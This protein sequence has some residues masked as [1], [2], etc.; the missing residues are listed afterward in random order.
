MGSWRWNP[1]R[2]HASKHSALCTITPAP[3]PP[4]SFLRPQWSL[5]WN[6]LPP[7]KRHRLEKRMNY[8]VHYVSQVL[9]WK[10]IGTNLLGSLVS[11]QYEPTDSSL[12][13]KQVKKVRLK[14][15]TRFQCPLTVAMNSNSLF[16]CSYNAVQ[17]G[18]SMRGFVESG[19]LTYLASQESVTAG[20][21]SS[22]RTGVPS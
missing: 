9:E 18:I 12:K 7:S 17:E 3:P 5:V 8:Y 14:P 22:W 21:R 1:G 4:L 11:L 15:T 10:I 19:Y 13:W 2:P 16:A 20:W 6:T